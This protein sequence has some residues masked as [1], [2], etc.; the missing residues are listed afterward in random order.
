MNT[1]ILERKF[2]SIE[3]RSKFIAANKYS[4]E[5]LER[6]KMMDVEFQKLYSTE[7]YFQETTNEKIN[8][9]LRQHKWFFTEERLERLPVS[10]NHNKLFKME[11]MWYDELQNIFFKDI[12]MY[13]DFENYKKDPNWSDMCNREPVYAYIDKWGNHY[14]DW[15][16]CMNT[17]IVHFTE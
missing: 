8:R 2:P 12:G 5:L 1:E 4:L 13:F 15:D 17:T 10:N 16:Y 3:E 6:D 11:A 9:I 7:K 14:E